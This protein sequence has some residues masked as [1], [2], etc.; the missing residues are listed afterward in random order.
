VLTLAYKQQLHSNI[1][2]TTYYLINHPQHPIAPC[3]PGY[4]ASLNDC[5]I[6][7]YREK[8]PVWLTTSD[9]LLGSLYVTVHVN[10]W[11]I[12]SSQRAPSAHLGAPNPISLTVLMARIGRLWRLITGA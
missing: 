2:P 12:G 5:S 8:L 1:L 4:D 9:F 7:T 6:N 10:C 11:L 3:F